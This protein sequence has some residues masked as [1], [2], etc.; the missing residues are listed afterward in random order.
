MQA[1]PAGNGNGKPSRQAGRKQPRQA[2]EALQALH[3]GLYPAGRT[4]AERK[5]RT[6]GNDPGRTQDPGSPSAGAG[7]QVARAV[8][9][10]RRAARN[11][12]P[13]VNR[14]A[15]RPPVVASP[16]FA[17]QHP[18]RCRLSSS[19][20]TQKQYSRE[21]QWKSHERQNVKSGRE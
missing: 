8:V 18:P 10:R 19:R 5:S 21:R 16:R 11:P 7:T 14:Q 13:N 15:G 6:A 1:H 17:R 3:P 9:P 12:D 20:W 4:Q 2:Q